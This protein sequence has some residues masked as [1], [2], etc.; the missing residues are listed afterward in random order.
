MSKHKSGDY[1]I[2]A[3]KYYLENDINYTK[4]CNIYWE[5]NLWRFFWW[6]NN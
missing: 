4:S 6:K 1:K 3:V 2:A 5:K